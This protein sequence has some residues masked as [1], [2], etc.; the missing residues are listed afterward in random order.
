ML[1]QK[2]EIPEIDSTGRQLNDAFPQ[3]IGAFRVQPL[4]PFTRGNYFMEYEHYKK[5]N[6]SAV[7]IGVGI[8]YIDPI[9]MNYG[10]QPIDW[11]FGLDDDRDY[12]KIITYEPGFYFQGGYKF[13][14]SDAPLKFNRPALYGH[15]L[16]LVR[17]I[18]WRSEINYCRNDFQNVTFSDKYRNMV[19]QFNILALAG[20]SLIMREGIS[21]D[22]FAGLGIGLNHSIEYS[23]P[24]AQTQISLF[25]RPN[26]P[27]P[28]CTSVEDIERVEMRFAGRVGF[29]LGFTLFDR[30][31]K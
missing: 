19:F 12:G 21:I 26:P 7:V 1:A 13:F 29:S 5:G 16:G 22:V 4:Q 14:V 9:Y 28:P 11:L 3:I 6:K 30:P 17:S 18:H 2:T 24:I 27:K 31:K 20:Y 8:T 10:R 23:K 15:I 25:S